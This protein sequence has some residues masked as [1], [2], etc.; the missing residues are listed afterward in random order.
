MIV[1]LPGLFLVKRRT[2]NGILL[3]P[4]L[5]FLKLRQADSLAKASSSPMC[6]SSHLSACRFVC[7]FGCVAPATLVAEN[8][9]DPGPGD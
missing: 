9:L 8:H 3:S 6:L 2:T 5:K 1:I 4:G 7:L